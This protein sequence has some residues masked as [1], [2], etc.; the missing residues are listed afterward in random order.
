MARIALPDGDGP[1]HINEALNVGT[2]QVVI[3]RPQ[4]KIMAALSELKDNR[5]KLLC[6]MISNFSSL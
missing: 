5:S 4:L 1:G 3:S 2:F 6:S